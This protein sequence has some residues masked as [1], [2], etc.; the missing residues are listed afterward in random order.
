MPIENNDG[1]V[2]FLTLSAR[3][4]GIWFP[5]SG[6]LNALVMTVP[7]NVMSSK[8]WGSYRERIC[9]GSDFRP[10]R[11]FAVAGLGHLR[12]FLR[13]RY[14]LHHQRRCRVVLQAL[15]PHRRK[16]G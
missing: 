6:E 12:R 4:W 14:C 11:T 10:G 3:I 15:R 5:H 8:V 13:R 2:K 1:Y 9:P 16:T 7:F